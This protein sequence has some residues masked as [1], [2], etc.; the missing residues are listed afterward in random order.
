M[1]SYLLLNLMNLVIPLLSVQVFVYVLVFIEQV[2]RMK[3]GLRWDDTYSYGLIL[4]SVLKGSEWRG[5]HWVL[6]DHLKDQ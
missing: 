1:L 4:A 5:L 3:C 6:V 2:L